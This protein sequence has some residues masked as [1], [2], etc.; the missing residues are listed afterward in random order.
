V[1]P[2]IGFF[3]KINDIPAIKNAKKRSNIIAPLAGFVS[4]SVFIMILN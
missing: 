1:A 2:T 4:I 3:K